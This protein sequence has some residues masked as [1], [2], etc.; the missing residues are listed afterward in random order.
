LL[1]LFPVIA[2]ATFFIL[3]RGTL[4]QSDNIGELESSLRAVDLCAF[5]NLTDDRETEFL[6]SVLPPGRYRH[7][8]RLRIRAALKYLSCLSWNSAV[9]QKIGVIAGRSPDQA[10]AASGRELANIALRTRILVLRTYCKLVPQL[11]VPS[12]STTSDT[13][14][15]SDYEE[16]RHRFGALAAVQQ[17]L[18]VSRILSQL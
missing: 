2:L 10:I 17:P 5:L 1:V 8:A 7:V 6:R 15:L 18:A 4:A 11:V 13:R 12:Y 3:T 9:L 14:L 16:L